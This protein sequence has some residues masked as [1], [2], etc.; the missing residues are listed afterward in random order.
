M[1]A[2]PAFQKPSSPI[3]LEVFTTLTRTSF[4]SAKDWSA[5]TFRRALS[6]LSVRFSFLSLAAAKI[7]VFLVLA[8][9]NIHGQLPFS[10]YLQQL[11]N[12]NRVSLGAGLQGRLTNLPGLL[13]LKMESP[14]L[15]TIVD[16]LIPDHFCL[17]DEM[18]VFF[19][20]LSHPL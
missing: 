2:R 1:S 4:A 12:L 11:I 14:H 20:Q 3:P 7:V 15:L 5:S 9:P 13:G 8:R 17:V 18:L 10:F 16:S 6:S 19:S